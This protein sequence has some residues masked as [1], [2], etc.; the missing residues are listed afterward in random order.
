MGNKFLI[1]SLAGQDANDD[2]AITVMD[3]ECLY[4]PQIAGGQYTHPRRAPKSPSA[5]GVW[6][7]LM[8]DADGNND[9]EGGIS[10]LDN[11]AQEETLISNRQAVL[12]L[13][14]LPD[15]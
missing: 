10:T 15:F 14:P 3:Y 2:G 5:D 12:M 4:F 1:R 9:N 7:G 13:I 6:G 11:E 8:A